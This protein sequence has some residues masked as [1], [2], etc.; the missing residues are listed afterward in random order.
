M[1]GG[2]ITD[3]VRSYIVVDLMTGGDLRF[4]INRK[5]F[6]EDA[7]KFWIAELGCALVP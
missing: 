4:H 1:D 2:N 5:T 6:T 3:G 7:V